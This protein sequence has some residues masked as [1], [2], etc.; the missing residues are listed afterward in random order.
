MDKPT[1]IKLLLITLGLGLF[2]FI[3]Y[4]TSP[5][6]DNNQ[7]FATEDNA[8]ETAGI[9]TNNLNHKPDKRIESTIGKATELK[10]IDGPSEKEKDIMNQPEISLVADGGKA[11]SSGIDLS[12]NSD[13]LDSKYRFEKVNQVWA[14]YWKNEL[15]SIVLFAGAHSQIQDTEVACKSSI[16]KLTVELS[17]KG[18]NNTVATVSALSKKFAERNL[19]FMPKSIDPAN[20]KIILYSEP[21]SVP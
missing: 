8:P 7:G 10:K 2:G 20:G 17:E 16:C 13:S 18:P 9:K 4:A 14:G 12:V 15:K 5:D 6:S 3:L 11:T 19:K 21:G 1:L